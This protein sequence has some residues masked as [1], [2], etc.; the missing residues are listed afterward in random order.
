MHFK[1]GRCIALRILNSDRRIGLRIK[2]LDE[3]SV[4]YFYS[5]RVLGRARCQSVYLV[6]LATEQSGSRVD[7]NPCWSI[8]VYLNTA[9][10]ISTVN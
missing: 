3:G 5:D 1:F 8:R 4:V 9:I 7:Y 2:I 10:V 6:T